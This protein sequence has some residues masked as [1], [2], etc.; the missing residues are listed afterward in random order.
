MKTGMLVSDF[1][2]KCRHTMPTRSLKTRTSVSWKKT[3]ETQTDSDSRSQECFRCVYSVLSTLDLVLSTLDSR[4]KNKLMNRM[5][6][7]NLRNETRKR[8]ETTKQKLVIYGK[9]LRCPSWS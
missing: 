1:S 7:G 3:A 4:Q 6:Y 2:N 8:N 5:P 9:A